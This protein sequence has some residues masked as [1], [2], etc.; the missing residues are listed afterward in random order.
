MVYR[1]NI[2]AKF[3]GYEQEN[4]SNEVEHQEKIGRFQYALQGN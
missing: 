4:T 2:S 3:M 1:G